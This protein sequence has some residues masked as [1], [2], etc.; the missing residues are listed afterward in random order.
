[1]RFYAC[2]WRNVKW[3]MIRSILVVIERNCGRRLTRSAA[4]LAI[5]RVYSS[6][7]PFNFNKNPYCEWLSSASPQ[8]SKN[9]WTS[10]TFFVATVIL[11]VINL[12]DLQSDFLLN[13][14]HRFAFYF[15]LFS[16][17]AIKTLCDNCTVYISHIQHL[18]MGQRSLTDHPN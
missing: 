3:K 17:S 6:V 4:R 18:R 1:M 11:S 15:F 8:L 10:D 9:D 16:F 7:F 14:L 2:K 5:E 13:A 12:I